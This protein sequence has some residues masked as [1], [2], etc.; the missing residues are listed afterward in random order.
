MKIGI[1]GGTGMSDLLTKKGLKGEKLDNNQTGSDHVSCMVFYYHDQELIY[2]DRHFNSGSFVLPH[3]LRHKNYMQFLAS[4]GVEIIFAS[5]AVG[6]SHIKG[7]FTPGR[8]VVPTNVIDYINDVYTFASETFSHPIA[9]HRPVDHIFC[10]QLMAALRGPE[11]FNFGR[12][13][14]ANSVRGPRYETPCEMEIRVRDGVHLVGMPTAFPEAVL[15]GELSI[16]YAVLC[17]VSNMAPADHDGQ[18]VKDVML[19]ISVDMAERMLNAVD[20]LIEANGHDPKCPCRQG[21]ERSVFDHVF[22]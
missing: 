2:I 16:P 14:L 9:F 11:T 22:S 7:G 5:S 15:A 12:F 19:Q 6:A 17:G 3:N 4:R 20:V 18:S 8:L 13:V 1:I 10:P 21:R